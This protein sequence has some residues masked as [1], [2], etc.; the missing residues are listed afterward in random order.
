M[1]QCMTA[2]ELRAL[3]VGACTLLRN[4]ALLLALCCGTCALLQRSPSAGCGA[5]QAGRDAGRIL[6]A[7]GALWLEEKNCVL[8]LL[9]AGQSCR[10][11]LWRMLICGRVLLGPPA[12]S[13]NTQGLLERKPLLCADSELGMRTLVVH[14]SKQ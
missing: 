13:D 8:P 11:F 12:V 7:G 9:A 2:A 14:G 10:D 1:N 5:Q 4:Y 6:P 3:C